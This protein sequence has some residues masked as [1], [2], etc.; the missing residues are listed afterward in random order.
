[1]ADTHPTTKVCSQCKTEKPVEMFC[2]DS[3]TRDGLRCY[4]RACKKASAARWRESNPEKHAAANSRWYKANQKKVNAWNARWK[5][6]HPEKVRTHNQN[7]RAKKREAGGTLSPNLAEKLF[8]LQRGKCACCG[9]PLGDDYHLDH[10]VPL[11]LGGSN[12]DDNIQ[13]LRATCNLQKQDKHP[14]DFMQSKG[15]L[16]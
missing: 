3:S 16:I 5:K 15:L 4:C 2:K 1:M 7:R 11:A 6:A 12:T 8:K 10:I 9:L 13:L 14:V